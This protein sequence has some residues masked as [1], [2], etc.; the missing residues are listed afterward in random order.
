MTSQKLREKLKEYGATISRDGRTL[1]LAAN[2]GNTGSPAVEYRVALD[3]T[4]SRRTLPGGQWYLVTQ[5]E[6]EHGVLS[7]WLTEPIPLGAV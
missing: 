1:R 4:I 6:Q 7:M 5:D 3:G 2:V